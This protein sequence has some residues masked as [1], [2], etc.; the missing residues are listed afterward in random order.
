VRKACASAIANLATK[1]S[2][3][4]RNAWPSLWE[5][6]VS[7]AA[8]DNQPPPLRAMCLEVFAQVATML[9]TTYFASQLP[10]FVD[11]L[12]SCLRNTDAALRTKAV[13]TVAEFVHVA[14]NEQMPLM[15]QLAMHV[16]NGVR[17]T[18]EANNSLE[19][20]EA[21]KDVLGIIVE[22][23]VTFF[24]DCYPQLFE[25]LFSAAANPKIDGEARY[26]C[27]GAILS[28]GEKTKALKSNQ[29]F[30]TR[31]FNLFFEY[32]LHPELE[33]DWEATYEKETDAEKKTEVS[34]GAQAI[35]R[36]SV[37]VR[38][39]AMTQL[40]A[41]KIMTNVQDP[42]WRK[43]GAALL[44]L[45]YAFEGASK[46]FV[47][48]LD[49]ITRSVVIPCLSD[50]NS[51][52]RH[53]ALQV[54]AQVSSDLCPGFMMEYAG[55]VLPIVCERLIGD[56]PRVAT[57]AAA[58]LTSIFDDADNAAEEEDD[59]NEVPEDKRYQSTRYLDSVFQPVSAALFRCLQME[60]PAFVHSEALAALS[61]M[62][63]V[64]RARARPITADV[65][66]CCNHF[67]NFPGDD[68]LAKLIRCRAIETTTLTASFV[69]LPAFAPFAHDVCVYLL[70]LLKSDMKREDMRL[71]YVLRGWTCMVECLGPDVL[72]YLNDVMDPVLTIAHSE[73]DA[74]VVRHDVGDDEL[75][76]TDQVRHVRICQPGKGERVLRIHTSLVED[77]DLAATILLNFVETLKGHMFP[78][79]GVLINLGA[80]LIKFQA[81][82]ETRES[83]VEL[84]NSMAA[85]VA[86]CEPQ[87]VD[88]YIRFV[89]PKILDAID[90]EAEGG[91]VQVMLRALT[92]ILKRAT[93][94]ALPAD[95]CEHAARICMDVYKLSIS[96][97]NEIQL[98]Q[99]ENQDDEEEMEDLLGEEDDEIDLLQD[100]A[101]TIGQLLR[102][103]PGFPA[104]FTQQFLPMTTSLLDPEFSD[105]Q[106]GIAVHLLCEFVEF[107]GDAVGPVIG[108]A[109]STFGG[110]VESENSDVA[111]AAAYGLAV[112]VDACTR[113][114]PNDSVANAINRTYDL[115][116]RFLSHP[117]SRE[118]DWLGVACNVVATA[119][120]MIRSFGSSLP[121][122]GM[123]LDLVIRH[124]PTQDDDIE[125]ERIN[126]IL[127]KFMLDAQHPLLGAHGPRRQA[128]IA[129]LRSE[130]AFMSADARAALQNM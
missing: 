108:N 114:P 34:T 54:V 104:A 30:V 13:H 128:V 126:D 124:L 41:P 109:Q 78:Y 115:C 80:D 23:D 8:S 71:R 89:G 121:D 51:Y 3:G 90:D 32:M 122:A 73:C 33:R 47:K 4:E 117:R 129:A 44:T 55:A 25:T 28:T 96:N 72:R 50:G 26:L 88:E 22:S 57:L 6:L 10:R 35:D 67:L 100:T 43:R 98:K 81:L 75:K 60:K 58:T 19:L 123:L 38:G 105:T 37:I 53:C 93:P 1:L 42:D 63:Q 29:Q 120:R 70:G 69:R 97:I 116:G 118:D 99:V 40:A 85:V 9:V 95:L 20:T 101:S 112:L 86:E 14:T 17:A 48:N 12:A 52:V 2:T 62:V 76:D 45:C 87:K 56:C 113:F 102:I 91:T 74:E 61:A 125:S 127:V 77:K 16:V 24:K 64:A 5:L 111:Q 130:K 49:T 107:G 82:S 106:H 31:L 46:S 7:T 18:V 21:A 65:V 84:L 11:A 103:V 36:L 59:E 94:G 15:S 39:R 79:M 66:N 83:G 27:I 68:E 92:A 119:V 110:F